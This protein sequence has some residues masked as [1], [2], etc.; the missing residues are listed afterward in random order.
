MWPVKSSRFR[1]EV[2]KVADGL[3]LSVGLY[4]QLACIWEATARK[5]GNIHRFQDFEE[6][7]FV[8][9]LLSAAAVAPVLET[10]RE[11]RVGETILEGIRATRQVV[12]TNT[13]LG[14]LLLLAPLA[15]VPLD[16]DLHSALK[17]VLQQLD[18]ADTRAV[19]E[20]IRL[21]N[22]GGLGR[23]GDQDV[24][25]EPTKSLGEVMVLS[26]DR[27]M[28]ARQYVTGFSEIING[29]VP[30]LLQ[31][32]GQRP[33]LSLEE[34]IIYCHLHLMAQYPDSLIGR[35]CGQAE[36]AEAAARAAQVR[37]RFWEN[38]QARWEELGKLDGW[39]REK[40]NARNP[41]T[42]ADLVTA[43][44]FIALREGSIQLPLNFPFSTEQDHG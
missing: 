31:A 10:A 41:G 4:A 28:V 27:D 15:T 3:R 9:L 24:S 2:F 21:A 29:G 8:D 33:P 25:Q 37:T 18:G 38:R 32:L 22:P 34:S 40:G 19:Y 6:T 42:T 7:T 44:L 17:K 30:A 26:A 5:P 43:C 16:Y 14:I 13:N 20:A 1:L 11:R 35:K 36:A 12:N 39:L 23:V